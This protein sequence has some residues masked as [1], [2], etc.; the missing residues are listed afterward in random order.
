MKQSETPWTNLLEVLEELTVPELIGKIEALNDGDVGC[1]GEGG[2]SLHHLLPHH[3][4]PPPVDHAV[5][6]APDGQEEQCC[7]AE[8]YGAEI[9]F[10]EPSLKLSALEPKHLLW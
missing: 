10:V 3:V 9:I 6:P 5:H 2:W 8:A 4:A 7:Q 1:D